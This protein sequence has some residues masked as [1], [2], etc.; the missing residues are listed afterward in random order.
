MPI[1]LHTHQ[2]DVADRV[3]YL[4]S[5]GATTCVGTPVS[6][7]ARIVAL[8][9]D[10]G[11]LTTAFQQHLDGESVDADTSH[12]PL[13]AFAG[14][15]AFE[16]S[17]YDGHDALVGFL[18]IAKHHGRLPDVADYVFN[19]TNPTQ[20]DGRRR[21]P[22]VRAHV[23][24][25]DENAST[26]ADEILLDATDGKGSWD[27]FAAKML[28]NDWLLTILTLVTSGIGAPTKAQVDTLPD[29]YYDALLP[30]WSTLTLADKTSAAALTAGAEF[31]K[32]AYDGTT[33]RLD[34]L[35][36]RID[37]LQ[38]DRPPDAMPDEQRIHELRGDAHDEVMTSLEDFVEADT[39]V[40]SL[41]LPTGLGKTLTGLNAGLSL[42]S[43]GDTSGRLIYALPFTSI[44][45][46]VATECREIFE[47][48]GHD[49]VLTIDHHLAETIVDTVEIESMDPDAVAHI[50]E[51]LGKSWR[52]GMVITTFVQLFESLAGPSNSRS[53]KLP[54]LDGS[55]IIID[56][57]QAVPEE[58][59]PLVRRLV[60]MLTEQYDVQIIVMTATQPKVFEQGSNTT[61]PLIEQPERYYSE[62]DRVVFEIDDSAETFI[63][64]EPVPLDYPTAA[65]SALADVDS[66]ESMLAICN[67]ID[68]ARE[69]TDA[70]TS[71]QPFT[72]LNAVY[73]D[74]LADYEGLTADILCDDITTAVKDA[75]D[76][77]DRILLH[78]TTRHRPV[79]RRMLIAVTKQLQADDVPVCAVT[80]Q[81]VEAGVDISFDY[82]FRD[83]APMSSIVQA[84]GRCNRS[85]ESDTGTVTVWL[86]DQPADT[87]RLPTTAVYGGTGEESRP[88]LTAQAIAAC[89]DDDGNDRFSE[90]TMTW[91]VVRAYFD[92]LQA[93]N[94]GQQSYV[95]YLRNSEIRKLGRQ[96]LIT[97]GKAVDVVV[98]RTGK[99]E[100]LF[101]DIS[102]HFDNYD[103]DRLDDSLD[104][105]QELQVSIPLYDGESEEARRINE[106]NPIHAGATRRQVMARTDQYNAFSPLTGLSIPSPSVDNRFL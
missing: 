20:P 64:N 46:Q 18:A 8:V 73:D 92:R 98:A 48:S 83:F 72:S 75:R 79:D 77:R 7:L 106:L 47:T 44:I 78:L 17:G 90:T 40:A 35:T 52:S 2:Q 96:S 27:E 59:W 13:G 9:H 66:S 105:A 93:R 69:L 62:L 4:A 56:E 14:F 68:S 15:Y 25:I 103:F 21:I 19:R 74:H 84:A 70:L 82:I 24:D 28:D 34:A 80:T 71:R 16:V 36:E 1:H 50:E 6:E 42:L 30:V 3:K 99:E 104:T 76:P 10:F 87:G 91:D 97:E 95:E 60:T 100:K 5:E 65:E 53:L 39:S 31:D 102:E 26:V 43:N 41:T 85:F 33:P 12:A 57:P 61:Y 29:D 89:R 101:T 23:E 94:P 45:D 22:T 88:K 37:T 86:L 55:V 51:L 38:S 49:E 54:A 67:T 81:L 63:D 32:T 58:W 11:K